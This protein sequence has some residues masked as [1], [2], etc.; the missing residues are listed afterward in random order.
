MILMV[1]TML[2]MLSHHKWHEKKRAMRPKRIAVLSQRSIR[3]A[4]QQCNG[5][6]PNDTTV[7]NML[8]NEMD[9]HADTSCAGAN[10]S[11]MEYTGQVCEVSPFLSSYDP[12]QEIPVARCCTVW[13][14][15]Q[16]GQDYL[17]VGDEMLWFGTTMEHSLINPNQIRDYGL[18]VDDNPYT[19]DPS[20]FG[21]SSDDVFIPFDTTGMLVHFE[22]RVPAAWE[23]T[24]LPIS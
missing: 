1:F 7:G 9:T 10:W 21:I 4:Q 16:S 8:R 12:V 6:V 14:D 2:L 3:V 23:K 22:S 5:F 17:L 11:M 19:D 13:T 18:A 15:D 24:H 20:K